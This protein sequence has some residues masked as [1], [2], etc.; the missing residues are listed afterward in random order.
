MTT[1]QAKREIILFRT[2]PH[3]IDYTEPYRIRAYKAERY[4]RTLPLSQQKRAQ[5]EID[6][7]VNAYYDSPAREC[8]AKF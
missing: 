4:L 8:D 3:Q 7:E 1:E 5:R 6:R 2:L